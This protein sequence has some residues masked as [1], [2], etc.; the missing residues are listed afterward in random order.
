MRGGNTRTV[1]EPF[2]DPRKDSGPDPLA[3]EGSGEE[4]PEYESEREA[5][6]AVLEDEDRRDG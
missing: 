5:E 1:E 6:E 4:E 2:E 3:E